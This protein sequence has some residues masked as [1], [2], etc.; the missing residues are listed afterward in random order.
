[1][2]ALVLE[3]PEFSERTRDGDV[4]SVA[5]PILSEPFRFPPVR[6]LSV[7]STHVIY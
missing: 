5:A 4:I 1:M 7:R 6:Q 3:L 2:R